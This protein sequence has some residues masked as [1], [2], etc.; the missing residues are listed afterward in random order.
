MH[1]GADALSDFEVTNAEK[2]AIRTADIEWIEKHVGKLSPVQRKW[3]EARRNSEIR[4]KARGGGRCHPFGDGEIIHLI[5]RYYAKNFCFEIIRGLCSKADCA[6][7][8][9]Q[10]I[11][12][13]APL[14]KDHK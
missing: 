12:I 5:I 3:L 13:H 4:Q 10:G 1:C 2:L 6:K 8:K 11:K 14:L 9:A 7:I